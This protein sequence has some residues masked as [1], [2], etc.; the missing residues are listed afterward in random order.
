[1]HHSSNRGRGRGQGGVVSHACIAEQQ[2]VVVCRFRPPTP[3]NDH[4]KPLALPCNP[5]AQILPSNFQIRGMHT[6][7][8]DR[9]TSRDSFVF[10]TD[11]LSG[12][13]SLIKGQ[14]LR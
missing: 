10:M 2:H 9:T 1:M 4:A 12:S 7:L 11:R 8:R 5:H 6:I 14:V 13:G 3:I